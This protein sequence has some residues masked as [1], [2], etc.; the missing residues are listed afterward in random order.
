MEAGADEAL[1]LDLHGFVSTC[2][3]TNFFIVKN[4]EVLTSTGPY[5]MNGITRPNIIRVCHENHIPC[6]QTNFSLFDVYSADE[7][8]VTG[9]LAE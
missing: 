5:C 3:A 4:G 2:N 9:T 1:M 7:A 8:F 6:H